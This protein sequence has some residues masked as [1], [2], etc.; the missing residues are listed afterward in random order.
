M[1]FFDDLVANE[2]L[3]SVRSRVLA[4]AKAAGL[5]VTNWLEGSVGQ[6]MAQAVAEAVHT[7][8][9][10]ATAMIRGY[11]SLDTS[12]DP[13]D[14]DPYDEANVDLPAGPGYLSN[15]GANVFG[16]TRGEETFATGFVTFTN[17]GAVA[18][19]LT[20]EQLTFTWTAPAPPDPNAPPDPKPT[21]RNAPDDSIYVGGSVTVPAG[22]SIVL[23]VVAEQAGPLSNAPTSGLTLTT[24]LVGCSATNNSPITGQARESAD[25]FRAR[26]RLAP[27]RVSLAGPGGFYEYFARTLANGDPL[28]NASDSEVNI[29]RVWVSADSTTGEVDVFYASPSGAASA[30]DV[31]AANANIEQAGVP[32]NATFTGA[33]ATGVPITVTGT[34][35][36][37]GGADEAT[38]IGA[39]IDA[40]EAAFATFD[41][42]GR[43]QVD[44]A[45]VIY[46]EDL[47]AI[48][49]CAFPGIYNLT[50]S[51]PA[52]P[53]TPLARGQVATLVSELASWGVT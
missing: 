22:G 16:T 9:L 33:A 23:P 31:T 2:T 4:Y 34:F 53:T 24:T 20:P 13:G 48:A 18:R 15:L 44:G 35:S 50:L 46:T 40:L 43:D 17:A 12:T 52:N 3:A 7:S 1:T 21:Y 27:N 26:C 49:A 14:V 11:A 25:A 38:A 32:D 45:G 36:L 41:I 39:V 5:S 47:Q 51:L 8:T 6:Q 29:N 19:V 42:G 28:R 30:E 37:A 10:E